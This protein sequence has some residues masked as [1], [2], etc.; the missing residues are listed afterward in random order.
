MTS[1]TAIILFL[2]CSAYTLS[3]HTVSLY[4]QYHILRLGQRVRGDYFQLVRTFSSSF[5]SGH[6]GGVLPRFILYASRE[7]EREKEIAA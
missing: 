2:P 5:G 3:K 4:M 7:R 6:F 1:D